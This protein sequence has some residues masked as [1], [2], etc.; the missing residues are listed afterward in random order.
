MLL[1]D[2]CVQALLVSVVLALTNFRVYVFEKVISRLG[3]RNEFPLNKTRPVERM[4]PALP[5][6]AL[7]PYPLHRPSLPFTAL[8]VANRIH[9]ITYLSKFYTQNTPISYAH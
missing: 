5:N 1:T 8:L 3:T 2:E 9:I 7:I 6:I 4:L